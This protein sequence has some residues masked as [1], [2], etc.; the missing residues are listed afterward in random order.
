VR[1]CWRRRLRG[2]GQRGRPSRRLSESI[3]A[4][5]AVEGCK[6]RAQVREGED[7]LTVGDASEKVFSAGASREDANGWADNV[8]GP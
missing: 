1:R 6:P 8:A 4:R 7:G 3:E 5:A 2:K